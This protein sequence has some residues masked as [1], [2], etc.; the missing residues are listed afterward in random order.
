MTVLSPAE[1]REILPHF[2][3]AVAKAM[4]IHLTSFFKRDCKCQDPTH[5]TIIRFLQR[6]LIDVRTSVSSAGST[7][8]SQIWSTLADGQIFYVSGVSGALVLKPE[9][10]VVP[11]SS[12][13]RPAAS[14]LRENLVAAWEKMSE[15]VR[16]TVADSIA[17]S[18]NP[19]SIEHF[20]QGP[21][22]ASHS[23]MLEPA[24]TPGQ[25]RPAEKAVRP[26]SEIAADK[27]SLP[28]EG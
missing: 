2:E 13:P 6:A 11:L 15:A 8:P 4:A 5:P 3:T 21:P 19:A 24:L 27:S 22:Q 17:D 28:H 18:V 14:V 20:Q 1:Q 26:T 10:K 16:R 12:I 25:E 23:G 9:I 7:G